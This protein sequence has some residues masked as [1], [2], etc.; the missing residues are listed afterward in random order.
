[1][2]ARQAPRGFGSMLRPD[3]LQSVILRAALFC[4]IWWILTGGSAEAW[5]A[6]IGSVV[7]ALTVSLWL[8]PPSPC[9]MVVGELPVFFAFFVASSVKGGMQVAEMALQPRLNLQ[10]AML[11]IPLRLPQEAERIF[12][13]CML[14]LL[15]GTLS[16]DLN[17][18]RLQLHV[19]DSRLPIEQDVRNAELRVARLFGTCLESH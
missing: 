11:E 15:P 18:N 6:G 16:T 5:P 19:L 9:R 2:N 10:P 14:S 4:S 13:V 1:M 3:I 8:L 17:G 7:L 12:L